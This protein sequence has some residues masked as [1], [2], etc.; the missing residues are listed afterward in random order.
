MTT[1]ENNMTM[2][3]ATLYKAVFDGRV[4]ELRELK[5]KLGRNNNKH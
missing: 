5:D 2:N 1:I 4:D 3:I